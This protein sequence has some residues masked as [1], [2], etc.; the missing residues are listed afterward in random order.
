MTVPISARISLLDGFELSL[1]GGPGVVRDELSRC[2]QR[3]VAHVGLCGRLP[4]AVVAGRLWPDVP[5]V[6]AHGSLRSALWRLQ[7]LAPGVVQACG[8]TLALAPGVRVDVHE[9]DGW[10]RRVA[11]PAY[12]L[13]EVTPPRA[14]LGGELLPG[15]YDD[16]VLLERERLRQLRM[17]ALEMMAA[18]LSAA[19][20]HGEALEAAYAAVRAEPLRESAHRTVVRIHLAEGNASEALRAYDRFRDLLAD[21]LG[22]APSGQMAQLVRGLGRPDDL[23]RP[24]PPGIGP[25]PRMTLR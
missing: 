7:K 15:W 8:G 4:R 21:E 17:H 9:L 1:G 13:E 19:G 12:R 3:V 10:A 20:R 5:E 18:R 11:D 16:W 24:R 6:H 23:V 2:V 25:V 14:A 22:V